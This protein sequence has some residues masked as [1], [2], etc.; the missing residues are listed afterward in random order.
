MSFISE[1]MIKSSILELKS[2]LLS[3]NINSNLTILIIFKVKDSLGINRSISN[4]HKVTLDNFIDLIE[5]FIEY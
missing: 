3:S 1:S 4:L 2:Q 5:L